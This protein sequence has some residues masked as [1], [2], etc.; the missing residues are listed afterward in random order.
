MAPDTANPCYGEANRMV[1]AL[2]AKR[3]AYRYETA[4]A[5]RRFKPYPV[6]TEHLPHQKLQI[7]ITKVGPHIPSG[8]KA[9]VLYHN[10]VQADYAG[11][12]MIRQTIGHLDN[13]NATVLTDTVTLSNSAMC[14]TLM[15]LKKH[16][17]R[18]RKP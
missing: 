6:L 17:G 7:R 9:D 4:A 8:T 2:T 1:S 13:E 16:S 14:R 11:T 5:E 15:A 10:A 18:S 12:A 3:E